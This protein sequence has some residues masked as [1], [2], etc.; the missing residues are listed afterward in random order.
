MD[1]SRYCKRETIM[2]YVQADDTPQHA[3]SETYAQDSSHGNRNR[4]TEIEKRQRL[5][6]RH[7]RICSGEIIFDNRPLTP[8]K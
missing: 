1:T 8:K 3:Q 7:H 6:L 2:I 5:K 4:G